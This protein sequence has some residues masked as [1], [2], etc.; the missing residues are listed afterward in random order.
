MT[1][2]DSSWA[3]DIP[4]LIHKSIIVS[5]TS[6][7]GVWQNSDMFAL[8]MIRYFGDLDFFLIQVNIWECTD[9]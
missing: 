2:L 3:L 6:Q 4:V 9:N 1:E 7:R 8:F 5:A